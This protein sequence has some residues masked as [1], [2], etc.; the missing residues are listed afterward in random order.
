MLACRA[1]YFAKFRHL[2]TR[3][4]RLRW[5]ARGDD[6]LAVDDGDRVGQGDQRVDVDGEHRWIAYQL[7]DGHDSVHNGL[8][9]E[10]ATSPALSYDPCAGRAVHE[11]LNFGPGHRSKRH[12]DLTSL[13]DADAAESEEDDWAELAVPYTADEQLEPS[14]DH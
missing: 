3:P 9:I 14:F 8:A 5:T 10:Q 6:D 12:R 7:R 4:S 1:G 13:L 11:E 2:A